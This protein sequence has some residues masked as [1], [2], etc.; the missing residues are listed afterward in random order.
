MFS[1]NVLSLCVSACRIS[2]IIMKSGPGTIQVGERFGKG[3][4]DFH[5]YRSAN[6]MRWENRATNPL[7][8][9]QNSGF[10]GS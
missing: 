2:I 6:K 4:D 9:F 7:V 1:V 10:L 5:F 8:G 3:L